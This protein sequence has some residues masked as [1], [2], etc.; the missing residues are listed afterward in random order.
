LREAVLQLK[1]HHRTT[2]A[3]PL[4][5]ALA[6]RLEQLRPQWQPDLLT[7]V[8]LHWVRY[9]QRGF[10]QA[11]LLTREVAHRTGVPWANSLARVRATPPQVG[12]SAGARARNL[13]GAFA[14][15]RGRDVTGLR[16][17]LIDDVTTTGATL[18]ACAIAL[19][20]ADAAEVYALTVT[21]RPTAT[22]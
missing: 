10:N 9:W 12:Q 5:G 1:F 20:A 11:E 18:A 22:P 3:R 13:H 6:V 7:P 2:L 17:V 15:Q 8:P 4:A 21:G 19:R 14:S 16:V